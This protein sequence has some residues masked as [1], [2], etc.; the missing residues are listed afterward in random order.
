MT[1]HFNKP[2]F[3]VGRQANLIEDFLANLSGVMEQGSELSYTNPEHH[4]PPYDETVEIG[5][6]DYLELMEHRFSEVGPAQ[7][8][9]R[10][11]IVPVSGG[12]THDK[13]ENK[14]RDENSMKYDR[15]RWARTL[16]ECHPDGGLKNFH[17]ALLR[18]IPKHRK[19][20]LQI[21]K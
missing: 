6:E 16:R 9:I 8:A 1:L 14:E 11:F 21:L 17:P 5:D 3:V 7:S 2:P 19:V 13:A 15:Y 12:N 10:L 4:R 18:G 20:T